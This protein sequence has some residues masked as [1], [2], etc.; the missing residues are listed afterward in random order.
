MVLQGH[1]L[2]KH[3]ELRKIISY[4]IVCQWWR[5]LLKRIANLP[6]AVRLTLTLALLRFV[7]P[8]MH[9][10]SHTTKCQL[11][12]SLNLTPG[13]AQTDGEG[14]E[15]PWA[16]IGGVASSIREMGPGSRE[17]VLNCH[18][19]F[20][21][22]MKLL[23]LGDRLRTRFERAKK[24]YAAQLESFTQFSVH[25]EARV[26]EWRRMVLDFEADNHKPNPYASTDKALTEADV[27]LR[28]EQEEAERV[29]AGVPGI[30][31]VSPS[32]FIAAGLEVED[33]QRRVRVQV[34]LKK[35]GTTAQQIDVVALRRKLSHSMRRLRTLQATYTPAA[36]VALGRWHQDAPSDVPPEQ[37]PLFLPSAL[38][39]EQRAVEPVAGL[40]VIEESLRDAQCSTALVR[41]RNQLH[42]KSRL[43][44][45]KQLQSRNQGAN[46]RARSIV[47]RNESKIRL[48]SEKYQMAWE[49]LRLLAGGD[50]RTL[51]WR[52]LVKEDIRCMQDVAELADAAKAQ[53][54]R[55][56]RR[57]RREDEL[58]A[59]GLLPPL[60]QEERGAR[61]RGG[62]N[63]R[64]VSWIW[65]AAGIG[66]TEA[67]L[68]EALRIEW[69]KAFARTR[70]WNEE[71][72]LVEEEARRLGVSL[73]Y[74]AEKW[75]DRV[76]PEA[77]DVGSMPV[78]Q[79]EGSIA[80]ALKQAAMYRKIGEHATD[81]MTEE[82]R[83]RGKQ[84]RRVT[85][86]GLPA[87]HDSEE[88]KEPGEEDDIGLGDDEEELEDLRGG[89]SD[90]E[91]M[92]DGGEDE[93]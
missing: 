35:A 42:M 61:E 70:R 14:I 44:T 78:E 71:V 50:P 56:E 86:E 55:T 17:D 24:E 22:W 3:P 16:H 20:W 58:R 15:R 46:T 25:Q 49:A 72:R 75:E 47:T 43:L 36:V 8:K 45:Y 51:S 82:R 29:Q 34:E 81:S 32:S 76:K 67:E 21:N 60:T 66:G 26:P 31:D 85:D 5:N 6:P 74:R 80:Y 68:E 62:E 7:I 41:L 23:G 33:Q 13:S 18:W 2:F 88:D 37:V 59:Q 63:V 54:A 19:S 9:I 84:R 38:S 10:H 53:K 92:L 30:H 65:T 27:L 69:A 93:D 39:A 4:D 64:E 83:G 48:H 12:F 77:L 28:L 87:L 91:F 11:M 57:E 79:A 90:E 52:K 73:E 89:V 1:L 40:A